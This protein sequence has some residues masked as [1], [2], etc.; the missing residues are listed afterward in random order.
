MCK[1]QIA[2]SHSSTE[3]VNIFLDIGL[4]LDG[5]LALDLWGRSRSHPFDD[6]SPVVSLVDPASSPSVLL[7]SDCA[8]SCHHVH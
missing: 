5:I 8:C 4:R 2:V 6:C 3:S 7:H 1:K